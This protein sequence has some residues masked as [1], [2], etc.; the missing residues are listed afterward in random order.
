M[1]IHLVKR[2][3]ALMCSYSS[4]T[5]LPLSMVLWWASYTFNTTAGQQEQ[6]QG[7]RVKEVIQKVVL[8]K[9]RSFPPYYCTINPVAMDT[10]NVVSLLLPVFTA[11]CVCRRRFIITVHRLCCSHS[12]YAKVSS[13]LCGVYM[14]HAAT[15]FLWAGQLMVA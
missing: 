7:H 12:L 4:L 10:T 5:A 2:S 15:L 13:V 3:S 9:E 11:A 14:S 1:L 8:R 6:S